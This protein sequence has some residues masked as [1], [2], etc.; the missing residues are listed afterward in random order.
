MPRS[1]K[2]ATRKIDPDPI[3]GNR[4][5]EKLVNNVM[6]DGKKT[7]AQRHVYEAFDSIKKKLKKDPIEVFETAVRNVTPQMEV[8]SRR[9]G[10]AAY[11]IPT[12][13]KGNRGSSLAIRWLAQGARKRSNKDFRTFSEKLAVEILDASNGEGEAFQRKISSHKMAEANKAF[14]HFRW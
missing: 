7:V 8:R 2:A 14:A 11:Q 3:Y 1:K 4:L 6:R 12:P 5:V 13:I 9:V 10:G